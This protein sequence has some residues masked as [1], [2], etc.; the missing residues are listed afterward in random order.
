MWG[1]DV[2]DSIWETVCY[3]VAKPG[4]LTY[5]MHYEFRS[6]TRLI[7][8]LLKSAIPGTV[9]WEG[10]RRDDPNKQRDAAGC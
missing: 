9:C 7:Y 5:T 10:G 6:E 4:V 1:R 2:V 8:E 3:C